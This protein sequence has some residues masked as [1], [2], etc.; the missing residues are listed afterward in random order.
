MGELAHFFYL[1]ALARPRRFKRFPHEWGRRVA[2]FDPAT[3]RRIS[4]KQAQQ[5]FNSG[6]KV[7]Y[8]YKGYIAT[9]I[10]DPNGQTPTA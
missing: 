10:H 4:T 2:W 8:R 1:Q 3:N 9:I 6:E 5:L 7:A